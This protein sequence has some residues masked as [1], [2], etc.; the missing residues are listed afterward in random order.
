[1]TGVKVVRYLAV[2]LLAA[3]AVQPAFAQSGQVNG[4]VTDS[5]GAAI[6]AA[7][8]T[9]KNLATNASRSVTTGDPGFYVISGLT[10]GRYDLDISKDSFKTLHFSGITV[11]VDQALT[12]NAVLEVSGSTQSVTVEGEIVADLNTTDAQVSNVISER[13]VRELPLITRDPYQLILLTPGANS[14]NSGLGGFSVN[15]N[16]D[17]NNNFMLDGADNNDPGVPAGGLATLNPDSTAEF[18]V[19]T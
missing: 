13:Q 17:R 11:T 2:F 10:P 6:P 1:M 5:T 19:I 16:R 12:L 15:G 8:I 18:R 9:A 7:A 4:V 3:C 14:T